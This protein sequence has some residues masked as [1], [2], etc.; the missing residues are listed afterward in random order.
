MS[1][2]FFLFDYLQYGV[3]EWLRFAAHVAFH[4]LSG[5]HLDVPTL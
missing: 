4:L 5:E 1:K 3:G 2:D